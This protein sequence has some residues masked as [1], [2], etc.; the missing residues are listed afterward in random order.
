MLV[1]KVQEGCLDQ[2]VGFRPSLP[3][4]TQRSRAEPRWSCR[5]RQW[6]RQGGGPRKQYR[7]LSSLSFCT[8]LPCHLYT[9]R[10][11]PRPHTPRRLRRTTISRS[12]TAITMS[13]RK[14]QTEA[15][16]G[17]G[18]FS[19]LPQWRS[20]QPAEPLGRPRERVQR[21]LRFQ[22]E[23]RPQRDFH[24]DAPLRFIHRRDRRD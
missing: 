5:N 4:T 16:C 6:G 8:R 24:V 2:A 20:S 9:T 15:T 14:F 13:R 23:I 12:S 10:W 7:Q 21:S 1:V 19:S 18:T 17:C 22:G 3:C 11:K